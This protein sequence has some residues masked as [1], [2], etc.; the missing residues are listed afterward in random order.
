MEAPSD[1][2]RVALA[3]PVARDGAP[4]L[5]AA[6]RAATVVSLMSSLLTVPLLAVTLDELQALRRQRSR[7]AA[8]VT[9]LAAPAMAQCA[10]PTPEPAR[11]CDLAS[12]KL[13]GDDRRALTASTF[14]CMFET[15]TR[16][17]PTRITPEERDGRVVGVRVWGVREGD[18]LSR[19]GFA[20]GDVVTHVAGASISEP[21]SA[22]SAYTRLRASRSFDVRVERGGCER[23]LRYD[24]IDG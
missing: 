5:R 22:L 9:A 12:V 14:E 17:R 11:A 15:A 10:Q 21:D 16:A 20:S 19:L 6:L 7:P 3:T 1:A 2:P 13:V 24:V 18:A 23:V 8:T 4:L